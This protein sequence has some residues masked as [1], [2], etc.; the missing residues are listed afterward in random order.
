MEMYAYW[1]SNTGLSV[2][3]LEKYGAAVS[4]QGNCMEC[5]KKLLWG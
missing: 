1:L 5:L 4:A 3:K 2:R